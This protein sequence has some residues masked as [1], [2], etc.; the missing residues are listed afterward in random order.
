[1]CVCV[2]LIRVVG[3]YSALSIQSLGQRL[4][5]CDQGYVSEVIAAGFSGGSPNPIFVPF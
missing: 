5:H 1:M 4:I 2:S 3:R